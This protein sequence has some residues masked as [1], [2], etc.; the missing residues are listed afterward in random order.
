MS[1]IPTG[2]FI[3]YHQENPE[4]WQE[5]KSLALR[6][7]GRGVKRY[8]AKC[9]MEVVRY[10]KTITTKGEFKINNS[11]TAH[12]ARAF[13]AKYPQHKDFFETRN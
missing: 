10:H 6:L 2:D 3:K 11:Y 4:I 1:K 7:I 13:I 5:F 8:G 12:Y 9:I